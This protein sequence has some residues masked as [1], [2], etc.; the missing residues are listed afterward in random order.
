MTIVY[1]IF[2]VVGIY[3]DTVKETN[4]IIP[5]DSMEGEEQNCGSRFQNNHSI[6]EI[7]KVYDFYTPRMLRASLVYARMLA[8]FAISGVFF[9]QGFSTVISIV[10]LLGSAVA[11]NSMNRIIYS[12]Y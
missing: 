9:L 3:L 12:L 1:F 11:F 8:L 10:A 6:V 5:T 4:K 7:F 2:I